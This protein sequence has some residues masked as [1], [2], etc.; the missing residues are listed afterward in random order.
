MDSFWQPLVGNLAVVALFISVFGHSRSL[1]RRL[2]RPARRVAF[3]V[4]MG[5]G[6]VTSMLMAVR[7]EGGG[8]L[9]LRLSLVA[10]SGF[11]GGPIA[12][13]VTAV[14]AMATRVALGGSTAWLAGF[15]IGVALLSGYLVSLLARRGLP[16][17]AAALILAATVAAISPVTS[18][19]LSALGLLQAM[20]PVPAQWFFNAA[21]TAVSCLLMAQSQRMDREAGLVRAA[22][23]QS[24]DFQYVKSVDLR[25]VAVNDVVAAHYG[26]ADPA[27]MAGLSDRELADPGRVEQLLAQD[28]GVIESGEPVINAED[29]LL[30]RD[31]KPIYFETSKVAVRD[32]DGHV[33]GLAGVTRDVTAD[34]QLERAL[35]DQRNQLSYV[36]AQ[37]SDGSRCSD[38]R[39]SA[40]SSTATSST[41]RCLR[42]P[43]ICGG[44]ASACRRSC[45]RPSSAAS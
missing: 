26:F 29:V 31:G 35:E 15:S 18:N 44:R 8:L 24:P 5:L 25:F 34:R 19:V 36:L 11:F 32:E 43:R 38:R 17:A 39:R 1:V 45:A 42:A 2:P 22:F 27:K 12:G 30:D 21:A 20:Q 16:A 9:D 6:T 33:I 10:L 28:R 4:V 3:G 40:R 37:M 23:A 14:I 7:V 13:M 41:A